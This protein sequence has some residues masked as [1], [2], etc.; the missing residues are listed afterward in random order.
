MD[1]TQ[2][3]KLSLE[4]SIL[5]ALTYANIFAYPLTS[6]EIFKWLT[7]KST[8]EEVKNSLKKNT[9]KFWSLEENLYFLKGQRM[10]V[11][12]RKERE[13]ISEQILREKSDFIS[14]LQ[15]HKEVKL[16][17]I[18]GAL[19]FKNSKDLDDDL[20]IFF[21]LK[22]N[23]IWRF[24]LEISLRKKFTKEAQKVCHNYLIAE[25]NLKL[26]EKD[27]FT[28]HQ[29]L[30]LQP[31]DNLD[32]YQKFLEANSWTEEF[33][34]NFYFENKLE[35]K[36]KNDKPFAL[37]NWNWIEDLIFGLHRKRLEKKLNPQLLG[38]SVK[39][40]KGVFKKHTNDFRPKITKLLEE[41]FERNCKKYFL[42]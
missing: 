2:L 35:L 15:N 25:D 34:P 12:I 6:K 31:A 21:I 26:I 20:D 24:N 38:G 9:D 7:R 42:K 4:E 5:L 19:C 36:L 28:A 18:S 13:K 8:F 32:F 30:N 3:K 23:S 10:L 29:L 17:A 27:F 40:E 1:L 16:V 22:N 11:K 33:F 39:I 41:E 37:P 14:K